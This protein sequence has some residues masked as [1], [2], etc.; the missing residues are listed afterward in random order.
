MDR[1]ILRDGVFCSLSPQA[2]FNSA[3][4]LLKSELGTVEDEKGV[5]FLSCL[6][7]LVAKIK[8]M[9]RI[10]SFVCPMHILVHA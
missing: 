10:F 3:V 5:W 8:D 2:V 7:G 9:Y 6:S 4:V 1:Y